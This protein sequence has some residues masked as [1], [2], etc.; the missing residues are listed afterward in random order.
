MKALKVFLVVSVLAGIIPHLVAHG[1]DEKG[2]HGG[3]IGMPGSFHTELLQE[4][5]GGFLVYLLDIEFKNPMV[6]SSSVELWFKDK[7]HEIEFKCRPVEDHFQCL[8]DEKI[9]KKGNILVKA[10]REKMIGNEASYEFPLKLA[11][12]DAETKPESKPEPKKHH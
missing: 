12:A 6:K 9:G 7:T 11:T 5:S 3:F 8:S 10:M 1:M 2:P 4:P